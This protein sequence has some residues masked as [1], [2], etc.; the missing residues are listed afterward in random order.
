MARAS[1]GR[2]A[3]FAAG[4]TPRPSSLVAS[5]QSTVAAAESAAASVASPAGVDFASALHDSRNAT[6]AGHADGT[7]RAECE[8]P[9]PAADSAPGGLPLCDRSRAHVIPAR[10]GADS[11]DS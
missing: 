2:G 5:Q 7:A 9:T 3:G 8:K 6:A 11:T 4:G 1:T 10:T